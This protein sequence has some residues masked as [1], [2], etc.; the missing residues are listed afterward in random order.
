M[1]LVVCVPV[2][3]EAG[4][5][6]GVLDRIAALPSVNHIVIVDDGSTDGSSA[7]LDKWVAG[8]K[9]RATLLRHEQNKGYSGA[10]LTGLRHTVAGY[11]AGQYADSDIVAT[12]DADGQHDPAELAGFVETMERENLDVVWARRDF[13]LYA[14]HKKLGNYYMSAVGTIF[15]GMRFHDIESGYCLFRMKAIDAALQAHKRDWR[16]S[17]SMTLAVTL[18][19]LGFKVSNEPIASIKIYRSRTRVIDAF[20]DTMALAHARYQVEMYKLR[21]KSPAQRGPF[22]VGALAW[23]VFATLLALIAV[24]SIFLSADSA[25]N[26]AHVW[27]ISDHLYNGSLPF[28]IDSLSNGKALAFPYAF[29]PWTF[30]A[31]LHP[32]FGDYAVTWTMVL[33]VL[34]LVWVV[35]RTQLRDPWLLTLFILFPALIESTIAFQMAYVWSLAFAFLYVHELERR[36]F[37]RAGFWLLLAAGT[38]PLITGIILAIHNLWLI[39]RSRDLRRPV[40]IMSVI[41]V[42]ALIPQALYLK[43]SS[44][45]EDTSVG[46]AVA[47]TALTLVPRLALFYLPPLLRWGAAQRPDIVGSTLMAGTFAVLAL[48]YMLPNNGFGQPWEGFYGLYHGAYDD[49]RDYFSS[50]TFVPGATYRVMEATNKEQGQY[51][52]I[53]HG[54]ILSNDFF[55]ETMYRQTWTQPEYETYIQKK[56]IDYVVISRGYGRGYRLPFRNEIRLLEA[57]DIAGKARMVYS[58]L[59]GRFVVYDVRPIKAA[60]AS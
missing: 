15:A 31:I 27:Y 35:W 50:T 54:A 33:G 12:V 55:G 60:V 7:V 25:N 29:I 47:I 52:F 37:V 39:G 57:E 58:D 21:R 24:R 49:Y 53:Q 23:T 46:Y 19:R 5:V 14:L 18:V 41:V 8:H 34:F 40:V 20:I 4:S 10:L 22:L 30:A 11:R 6:A 38:H 1:R 45:I 51:R 2:Y 43:S 36:R 17:I 26:Y 42:L 16:Y 9:D 13:S 44:S 48:F 56:T 32:A 28:H 59:K 3:N